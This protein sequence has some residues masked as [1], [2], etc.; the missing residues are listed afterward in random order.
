MRV[1]S[2]NVG[3]P[4]QVEH[5]GKTVVTGIYKRPAEGRVALGRLNFDGDGQ[6]DPRYHG[7]PSRAVYAYSTE[8]YRYWQQQLGRDDLVAG[9]FGENLTAEGWSERT[10]HL[11]DVFRV[12]SARLQVT[13][14]RPPCSKLALR[15]GD[16]TFPK[17]F[18]ASLRVGF[19]LAV[20]EEGAVG[21]GDPIERLAADPRHLTIERLTRARFI[22][23]GDRES[24]RLALEVPAL[25]PDWRRDL[26]ELLGRTER[27]S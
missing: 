9:Q 26:G 19:Y 20:V 27:P 14:P 24:L 2:V 11:G 21:A 7:G 4:R 16:P 3:K 12:G 22:D 13:Q 23:R 6:A 15:M 8:N 18:L 5:G 17:R 10:V 25:S 1:V